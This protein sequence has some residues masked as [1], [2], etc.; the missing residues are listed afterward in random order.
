MESEGDD[1]AQASNAAPTPDGPVQ[2]TAPAIVSLPQEEFDRLVVQRVAD[3][4]RATTKNFLTDL[5]VSSAD[6]AKA[7]I[8]AQKAAEDANRTETERA[9]ARAAERETAAA[10]R[11]AAAAAKEHSLNVAG[12]LMAAGAKGDLAKLARLVDV[13]AGAEPSAVA[14]AVEAAKTD[15]PSLFGVQ[16]APFAPSEPTGGGAPSR[17][18]PSPDAL[19]RG[20]ERAKAR[21][22]QEK[23]SFI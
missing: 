14:A 7:L 19:T 17:P 11:E 18:T 20:E 12:A 3:A 5:G 4:K 16:T 22:P 13:E 10:A 2:T 1:A 8:A 9:I 21:N 6:E 23:R 15:F